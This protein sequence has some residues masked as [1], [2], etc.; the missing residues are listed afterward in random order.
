MNIVSKATRVV[1]ALLF[2]ILSTGILPAAAHAYSLENPNDVYKKVW[3]CK[4]VGTPGIDERLK[5]GNDGLISVSTNALSGFTG[6]GSFFN[7]AQEKSI[8][9]A[10]DDGGAAPSTSMC[11][12]TTL[13]I[14]LVTVTPVC[15]PN[16]DVVSLPAAVNYVVTSD[17]GWVN[18]ARTIV[19]TAN[20][21]YAFAGG[22][23]T[24]TQ[25]FNDVAEECE[26]LTVTPQVP[27]VTDV[28]GVNG[29]VV[30]P[31]KTEHVSYSVSRDGLT[32]TVIATAV[33]GYTLLAGNGYTL[34]DD[35]TAILVVTP[36]NQPCEVQLCETIEDPIYVM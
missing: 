9:I 7:D 12:D 10:W 20:N 30:T 8:A 16:N 27:D 21:G 14:P 5:N 35:G 33:D 25:T 28:C 3:V 11:P 26:E 24:N 2:A 36:T 31:A 29:D 4:Y 34:R 1:F 23:T 32:V 6:L 15:G 17:S 22:A 19:W 13:Q 18:N